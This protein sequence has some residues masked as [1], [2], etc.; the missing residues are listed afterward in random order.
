MQRRE[1]EIE[2]LEANVTKLTDGIGKLERAMSELAASMQQLRAAAHAEDEARA[3]LEREYKIKK[4]TFDLLP[5]ADNNIK[6]L[7]GI[8]DES[9]EALLALAA[10]WEERR[11]PLV[12]VS[13][14]RAHAARTHA[15]T[16]ACRSAIAR[17]S[18]RRR[19]SRSATASASTRF[20][21][22]ARR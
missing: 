20:A 10:E 21:H 8:A 14:R 22:A 19:A 4:K 9:G 17:W 13:L 18:R 3:P 5:D 1:S 11:V 16:P 2:T 6:K 15:L 7:R 12:E